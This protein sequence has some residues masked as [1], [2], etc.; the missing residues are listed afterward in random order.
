MAMTGVDRVIKALKREEPDVVPHF[1]L[2]HDQKVRDAI[3]PGAS[4]EDF[5]EHMDIDGYVLFDKLHSWQ[6]ETID[7]AKGIVRDQ[8]LKKS[9]IP[10][11]TSVYTFLTLRGCH[12]PQHSLR[13]FRL[14]LS[15]VGWVKSDSDADPPHA[16][17]VIQ[18]G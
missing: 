10:A 14:T 5:V 18:V 8:A 3:L 11:A 6:H 12:A 4:Y 7:E 13:R 1:E 16:D 15:F 9:L 17:R 2:I